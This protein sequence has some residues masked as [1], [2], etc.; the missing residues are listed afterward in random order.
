[1]CKINE[2]RYTV[3]EVSKITGVP[4]D[5]LLHYD[6]IDLFKPK[7]VNPK[8]R[9]RYYTYEQ[10]WHLDI[11][12]CCR[13]LNIPLAKIREILQAENNR[14]IIEL[15]LEHQ[16]YALDKARY[17]TKVAEDI[18]WYSEQYKQIINADTSLPVEVK[19]FPEKKV[20]YAENTKNIKEYHVELLKATRTILKRTDS[21]RRFSGFIMDPEGLKKNNFMKLGE[22]VEFQTDSPIETDEK[23][24][25]I[26]PGGDYACCTVYAIKRQVDFSVMN[27][28]LN[29]HQIIPELVLVEEI[30]LQLFEYFGKGYPCTIR[31]KI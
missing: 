28:W 19:Y 31:V 30:G 25:R 21:F 29:E 20:I 3:G 11:I 5:T 26:L 15:M 7:Y 16:Q 24:F 10:F 14:K 27:Q 1:M 18:D 22:Y 12:I 23:Y 6:R 9:Y 17:F 2:T 13:N 8:T 4:K